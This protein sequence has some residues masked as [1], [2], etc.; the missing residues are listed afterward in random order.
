MEFKTT[1]EWLR[2]SLEL[3]TSESHINHNGVTWKYVAGF[4]KCGSILAIYKNDK[5]FCAHAG[6]SWE[7]NE[8]PLF[9]YFSGDL[10]YDDLLVKIAEKYDE[11]RRRPTQ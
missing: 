5:Q 10:S 8:E 11:I 2:A 6:D 9:G 1:L 4:R 7:P 3:A